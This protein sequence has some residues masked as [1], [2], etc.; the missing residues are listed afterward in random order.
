MDIEVGLGME[1][2]DLV[3]FWLQSPAFEDGSGVA[4]RV[5]GHGWERKCGNMGNTSK[6][7]HYIAHAATLLGRHFP[8]TIILLELGK[9]TSHDCS[10]VQREY[11]GWTVRMLDGYPQAIPRG[12]TRLAAQ[13]RR[14]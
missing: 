12:K 11:P 5:Q 1:V 13:G 10:L 8:R 14:E 4:G 9:E 3:N 6:P 7:R 2:L